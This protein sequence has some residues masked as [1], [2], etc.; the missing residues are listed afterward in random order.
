MPSRL[1]P[2]R[3]HKSTVPRA[4]QAICLKALANEPEERYPSV[5]ALAEDLARFQA[6]GRVLAYP[7]GFLGSSKRWFVK[8]RM[9]CVLVLAY[10]SMRILLLFWAR[11]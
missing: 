10:L 4:L 5:Q 9:A 8:Y 1:E 6:Q 2:P 11:S 7:E 3:R